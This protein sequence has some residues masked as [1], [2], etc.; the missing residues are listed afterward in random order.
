MAILALIFVLL[1]GA[2]SLQYLGLCDFRSANERVAAN[3]VT[4]AEVMPDKSE[5]SQYDQPAF[6]R[7]GIPMPE[8]STRL[9]RNKERCATE[10]CE[11][12]TPSVQPPEASPTQ[13]FGAFE[14]VA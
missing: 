13:G 12:I 5:W 6:L 9:S 7:R 10:K 14:L 11:T 8:H 1:V 4:V 3:P 2:A